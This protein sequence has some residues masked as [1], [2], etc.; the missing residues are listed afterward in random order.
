MTDLYGPDLQCSVH[1]PCAYK[2]KFSRTLLSGEFVVSLVLSCNSKNLKQWIDQCYSSVLLGKRRKTHPWGV[3]VGLHPPPKRHKKKRGLKLNVGSSFICF[4]LFPLSL[5]CV[6]WASQA[7]C[8]FT[9]G[10][11]SGPWTFLC[12]FF[13]GFSLHCLLATTIQDFLFLF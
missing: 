2:W 8:C 10:S 5:P 12:S 13:V 1:P 11:H 7:G 3:R 9:W 6:N 4:F